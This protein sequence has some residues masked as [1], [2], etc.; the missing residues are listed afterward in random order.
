MEPRC[1]EYGITTLV[2]IRGE[3]EV[4]AEGDFSHDELEAITGEVGYGYR[5]LGDRFGDGSGHG[6][7]A[8]DAV[9]DEIAGLARS[10]TVALL[11]SPLDTARRD[12]AAM[13]AP[14]LGARG[15]HVM[16]IG[17]DGIAEPHQ[18]QLDL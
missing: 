15:L 2:D 10:S 1:A 18:D 14:S 3:H 9:S 12:R 6:D 8:A 5:W 17:S 11:C 16:H 13:L 7:P 4:P